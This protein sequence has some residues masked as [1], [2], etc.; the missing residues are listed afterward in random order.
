MAGEE[1]VPMAPWWRGFKGEIKKT[2]E[3]K[4]EV[5]GI[6]RKVDDTTIEIT[7]LPVWEWTQSFKA[8]LEAMIGDKGEGD[9]K[10]YKEHH[11][12]VNVH[13][14]VTMSAKGMAKAEAQGLVEFFKL[15]KPMSTTNMICFNFE[16]KIAKYR[17]PEEIV[18]E[19][20]PK[21]L[22]YYQK[23]KVR[24]ASFLRSKKSANGAGT[25][26]MVR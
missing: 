9:V 1:M 15:S 4:Y 3:N 12:N 7:E 25:C 18:E 11:D 2:G 8:K 17:A 26:L 16:G 21:R 5:T 20:Y 19:F 6:A 24:L 10:D 23:R 13:F 14:V 22:A